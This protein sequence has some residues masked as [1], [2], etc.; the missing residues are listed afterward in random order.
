M[1]NI[2]SN[3]WHY[4]VRSEWFHRPPKDL[5]RYFWSVVASILMWGVAYAVAA[6]HWLFVDEND[7]LRRVWATV[8]M[9]AAIGLTI[10][11]LI[12][13]GWALWTHPWDF[14]LGILKVLG[15]VALFALGAGFVLLAFAGIGEVVKRRRKRRRAKQPL[16]LVPE[17]R[18]EDDGESFFMIMWH[19]LMSKKRKVCPLITVDGGN[20][21]N[22]IRIKEPA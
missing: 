14:L 17:P 20:E 22:V 11:L 15:F 5:C 21:D 9:I 3:S 1:L 7:R 10:G 2:S 8:A 4:R 16:T 19:F 18:P 6:L 13:A 12:W